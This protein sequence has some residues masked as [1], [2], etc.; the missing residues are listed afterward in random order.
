MYNLRLGSSFL[1]VTTKKTNKI[2]KINKLDFIKTRNLSASK[3]IS[4]EKTIH[5]SM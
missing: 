1:D 4:N 3:D 2:D 5:V